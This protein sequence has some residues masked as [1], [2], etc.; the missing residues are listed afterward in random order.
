M[1][2]N[3]PQIDFQKQFRT[4]GYRLNFDL[5]VDISA[6]NK[7][8]EESRLPVSTI[9]SGTSVD[10]VPYGVNKGVALVD[11]AS[12]LGISV[13]EIAKIADQGQKN[14]NDNSLLSGLG[15][16]S[17]DKYEP[18]SNQVSTVGVL[19]LRKVFATAW[20]LDNLRLEGSK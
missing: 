14:G 13:D 5:S 16:F 8:F 12:R 7:L 3:F 11:F 10:V 20:L 9:T 17:V 15:S 1:Q 4:D 19:G 18:D 2:I 6:L